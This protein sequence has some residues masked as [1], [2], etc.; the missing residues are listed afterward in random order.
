MKSERVSE[1]KRP[2]TTKQS[3]RLLAKIGATV[4][5]VQGEKRRLLGWSPLTE[6]VFMM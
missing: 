1:L 6:N 5:M 4:A 3:E 2:H